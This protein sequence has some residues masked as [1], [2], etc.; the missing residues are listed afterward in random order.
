VSRP[1]DPLVARLR[2]IVQSRSESEA[3]LALRA[4]MSVDRLRSLLGGQEAMTVDELILLS[5]GLQLE[6][7]D[8]GLDL[9]DHEDDAT[10]YEPPSA[11]V[12]P[13]DDPFGD[14]TDLG[15]VDTDALPIEDALDPL[16]NHVRQLFEVGFGLGCTFFFQA[17]TEQLED[18]GVP[19]MV[20]ERYAGAELPIQLDA[21][22]HAYNEPEYHANGVTL[23]LSFDAIYTCTFPWTS[24][25]RLAFFPEPPEVAP[26]DP[27]DEEDEGPKK[28]APF[29]RL[30]E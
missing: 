2:Q 15:D 9:E 27:P 23:K 28:G 20:L 19:R 25:R 8:L 11:A 29:L 5:Q 13:Y 18:S 22:Y 3:E 4:G 16:G 14:D 6:P 17:S 10:P 1:S 12:L 30:V 7:Q 26:D 21:A 24:I